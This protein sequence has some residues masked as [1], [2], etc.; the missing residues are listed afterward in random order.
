MKWLRGPIRLLFVLVIGAT[1]GCGD[2][3]TRPA[4]GGGQTSPF[5]PLELGNAWS[6]EDTFVVH[7]FNAD[8]G[9]LLDADTAVAISEV[10][11]DTTESIGGITYVTESTVF[12]GGTAADTTWRRLRQD[13]EGLFRAY[14]STRVPPG[15]V[16]TSDPPLEL[17]RLR[18]PVAI[19]A[20]WTVFSGPPT[21]RATVE[22]LD[23]LTIAGGSCAAYRIRI[24]ASDQ[25][26]DDWQ[27]VWDGRCGR[28]RSIRHTEFIAIDPG[29]DERVR[30]VTEETK[31]LT[32]ASLAKPVTH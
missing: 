8:S 6:Y 9:A 28:V 15:D 11:L 27:R 24:D 12:R 23:T 17:V 1:A 29:A 21:V 10:R 3:A 25:R 22:S 18:Y 16:Q 32:N 30:I 5:Y 26:P 7:F 2:D 14:I 31:M 13:S 4:S 20:E 19:G